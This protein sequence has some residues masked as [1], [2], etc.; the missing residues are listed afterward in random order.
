MNK[1]KLVSEQTLN[2][3]KI[4]MIFSERHVRNR[5]IL[6]SEKFNEKLNKYHIL[7][8]AFSMNVDYESQIIPSFLSA[9]V[10]HLTTT[11]T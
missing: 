6:L 5:A 2:K 11:K 7:Q 3:I 8:F 1:Y 10:A 4:Y 9:R